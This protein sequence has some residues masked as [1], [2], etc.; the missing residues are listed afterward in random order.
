M[1]LLGC[2]PDLSNDNDQPSTTRYGFLRHDC[3]NLL[4]NID[5]VAFI[6]TRRH[7]SV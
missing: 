6:P 4:T 5:L 7:A 3:F 1:C 2:L